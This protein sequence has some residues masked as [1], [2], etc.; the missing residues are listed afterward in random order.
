VTFTVTSAESTSR[1][2]IRCPAFHV[3]GVVMRLAPLV[4][5]RQQ[6]WPC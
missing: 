2:V 4:A 6:A 3:F 5:A 1:M